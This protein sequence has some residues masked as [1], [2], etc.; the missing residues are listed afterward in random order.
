MIEI[1]GKENNLNEYFYLKE[2]ISTQE[3]SCNCFIVPGSGLVCAATALYATGRNI[4]TLV[5]R[6]HHQQTI[7]L[8]DPESRNC[9][10]GIAGSVT[11]LASRGAITVARQRAH[12]GK[13]TLAGRMAVTA[14]SASA[15]VCSLGV[16]NGLANIVEKVINNDEVTSLDVFQFTSCILFFT[17]SVVSTH[18]ACALI[19]VIQKNAAKGSGGDG[20][21]SMNQILKLFGER[22]GKSTGVNQL[23]R[24]V[25]PSFFDTAC[26]SLSKGFVG[27][28]T[29]WDICKCVYGKLSAFATR[30]HQGLMSVSEYITEVSELAQELWEAWDNEMSDVI[31]KICQAF[32]VK[33]WSDIVVNGIRV[34][35][36]S[37]EGY[38]RLL[39]NAVIAVSNSLR[40]GETAVPPP[41]QSKVVTAASNDVGKNSIV[42][43]KAPTALPSDEIINIHAKFVDIQMCKTSTEL[44]EYMQFVCE[45]IREEIE[46]EKLKYEKMWKILQELSPGVNIKDFD[47]K[48]GI[49]GNRNSYF[50]QQVFDKFKDGKTEGLSSLKLAYDSRKAVMRT[51]EKSGQIFDGIRF[52][53]FSNMT[54]L[55]SNGMLSEE[56][57][58]EI[59]RQLTKIHAD[60][61]NVS[62]TQMDNI[63][64][65]LV[66]TSE[67]VITVNSYIEHG[68]VSG[69][70]AVLNS[71]RSSQN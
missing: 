35:K 25:G 11:S 57:Y 51:Q 47:Q 45:Y 54:G 16:V 43:D 13:V 1:F 58:Y 6:S 32:G 24:S 41:E 39:C 7:G 12:A 49:S 34:L 5:D 37:D 42:L 30:L 60:K 27:Q 65:I 66:N 59:A 21:V 8:E 68:R 23:C 70:A 3:N 71:P 9:W 20:H 61:E 2:F 69:I 48:Y 17:N 67:F 46:K 62:I 14:A 52:H 44:C 55:A 64:V 50:M 15:H 56:Q 19:N 29:L 18:Q 4:Q 28:G 26:I 40:N 31:T 10:L 36:G 63:A 38:M 22:N 33:H 53:P